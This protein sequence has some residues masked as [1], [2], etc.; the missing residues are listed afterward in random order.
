MK[1]VYISNTLINVAGTERIWTDKMNYL[2]NNDKYQVYLITASQDNHQ[3][4]FPLSIKIKHIDLNI[5][6]HTQYQ[7]TYP[8]RLLIKWQMK[9][10]FK[11][12]L[13]NIIS[14]IDPDIIIATTYWNADVVCNLKCRGKK[15]IESHC[16]KYHTNINEIANLPIIKKISNHIFTW[17]YNRIIEKKSDVLITLTQNDAKEW[18]K[19]KNTMVIPNIITNPT[20]RHS[21]CSFHRAIAVG[22]LTYQKGFDL[23]LEVWKDIH[24]KHPDWRLDIFGEGDDRQKLIK[25]IADYKMNNC[26][27][28]HP[29]NLRIQKE[30]LNS[31]I[32]I[33]SSR[34]EGFALTL[35]EAMNCGVPCISFDCPHGPSEI[36]KNQ[37]D[38]ILVEN[39]NI[40]QMAESLCY[41]IENEDI[42]KAYGKEAKENVKRFLPENIMPQWEQ[43]FKELIK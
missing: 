31:S 27:T 40:H 42:R 38:G 17:R 6:F 24:A 16:V 13:R 20:H 18:K 36:I 25:Q 34:F 39:N 12:K 11:K 5:R 41:L 4:P 3:F 8:K 14:D 22:R 9:Q 23:L 26:V 19:A 10:N 7:Y 2:A 32:Y 21:D 43:L 28:I 1:I 35:I 33:L 29:T 15:I 30:Y 37:S